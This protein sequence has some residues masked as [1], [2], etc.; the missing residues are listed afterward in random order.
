MGLSD[1]PEFIPLD[2]AVERHQ[3]DPQVLHQ[4]IAD[5]T[6][7]IVKVGENLLVNDGD[8][9]MIVAETKAQDRGD[10]LVSLSEAAR[11]LG[12][13]SIIVTR[14]FKYGW[15]PALATGP[16]RSKLVSWTQAKALGELHH[17][18]AHRG[19]RLIPENENVSRFIQSHPGA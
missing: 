13:S 14:W 15:L 10:E 18:F 1:L 16:R 2:E 8:V 17:Q 7:R 9:H 19:N 6:V 11:R 4:A 3:L 12:F 5:D